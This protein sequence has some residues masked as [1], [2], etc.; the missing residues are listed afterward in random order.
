MAVGAFG[1]GADI[2]SS[3]IA[4]QRTCAEAAVLEEGEAQ[5]RSDPERPGFVHMQRSDVLVGNG[6]FVA[7][8]EYRKT[9]AVEAGQPFLRAHPE[10]A[11]GRAGERL[12]RALRQAVRDLPIVSHI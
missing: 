4:A 9:G 2:S 1:D 8:L 3:D 6:A 12:H 7:G 10:I 11:V 5:A